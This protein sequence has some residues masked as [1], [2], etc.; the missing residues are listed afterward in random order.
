MPLTDGH[1][2]FVFEATR[3]NGAPFPVVSVPRAAQHGVRAH[4]NGDC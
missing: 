2:N 1:S 3:R 4:I